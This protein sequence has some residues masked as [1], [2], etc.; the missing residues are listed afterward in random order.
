MK[1]KISEEQL[2]RIDQV[3]IVFKNEDDKIVGVCTVYTNIL[4]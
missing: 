4:K 3:I 2:K 1:V